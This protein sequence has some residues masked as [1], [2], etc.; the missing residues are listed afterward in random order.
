ML[1]VDCIIKED[2]EI[3]KILLLNHWQSHGSTVMKLQYCTFQSQQIGIVIQD[4]SFV[5]V[6]SF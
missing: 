1:E 6:A 3:S 2:E 4:M 5:Q